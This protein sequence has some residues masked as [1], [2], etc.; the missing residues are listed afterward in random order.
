MK[1]RFTAHWTR[2]L[3]DSAVCKRTILFEGQVVGHISKFEQFGE[4]EI[5]YWIGKE[6]WGKGIATS[7]LSA[8]LHTVTERPLYGRAAKDNLA[9]QR[10]LE[11]C[12]FTL[13]GCNRD[14]A[15]ARGEEIEEVIFTLTA[16]P[17]NGTG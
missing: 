17:G 12:G 7:A 9:S 8:F 6:Y 3:N 1:L 14:F 2:I 10:V 15:N 5:S 11:K 16:T 4:P 13:Q